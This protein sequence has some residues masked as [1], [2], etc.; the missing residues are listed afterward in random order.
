MDSLDRID[1]RYFE[2]LILGYQQRSREQILSELVQRFKLVDQNHDGV[3]SLKEFQE[4]LS[5]L[6]IKTSYKEALQ[7]VAQLTI[8][9]CVVLLGR[10]LISKQL[11]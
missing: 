1:F 4:L 3:I 5:F 2:Q 6:G 9:D 10:D 7:G 8:S 11:S